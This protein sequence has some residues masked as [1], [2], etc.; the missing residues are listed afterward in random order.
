MKNNSGVFHRLFVYI[1]QKHPSTAAH[2]PWAQGEMRMD[3][4]KIPM[5]RNKPYESDEFLCIK[6]N[7]ITMRNR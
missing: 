6:S 4:T 1:W 5:S 3:S 2:V 7:G